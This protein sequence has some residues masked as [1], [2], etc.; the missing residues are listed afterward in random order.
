MSGINIF[1]FTEFDEAL[2]ATLKYVAVGKPI[3]TDELLTNPSN[4]KQFGGR[5]S[6]M[7]SRSPSP[8][9]ADKQKN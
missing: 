3:L 1:G 6:C 2:L 8:A 5:N 4:M 9:T 7:I